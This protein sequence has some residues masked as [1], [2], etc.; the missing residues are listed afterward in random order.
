MKPTSENS[1]NCPFLSLTQLI[2][3]KEKKR[4]PFTR[5]GEHVADGLR[6]HGGIFVDDELETLGADQLHRVFLPHLRCE[7]E[8]GGGGASGDKFASE[9]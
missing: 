2:I 3:K 8:R 7:R 9:F 4:K 1:P 5:R 6:N